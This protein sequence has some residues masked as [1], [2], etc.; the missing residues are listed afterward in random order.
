M[1]NVLMEN[2]HNERLTP[3]PSRV[4]DELF[5][6]LKAVLVMSVSSFGW[7]DDDAEST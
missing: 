6:L 7:L 4:G 3:F 2:S 5:E 1:M